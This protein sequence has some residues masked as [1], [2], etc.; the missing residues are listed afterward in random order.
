MLLHSRNVFVSISV[1]HFIHFRETYDS[2]KVLLNS[3]N[4]DAHER[5]VCW[6]IKVIGLLLG[7]QL[8]YTKMHCF[9]V[10]RI[11]GQR[12]STV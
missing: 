10:S 6:D 5:L 8:G 11:A 4:D 1:V 3:V 12:V 7:L 2:L 9:C